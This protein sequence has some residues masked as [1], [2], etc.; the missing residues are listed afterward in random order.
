MNA[1]IH[2]L[3]QWHLYAIVKNVKPTVLNCMT[4]QLWFAPCVQ[5]ITI[6]Y[7]YYSGEILCIFFPNNTRATTAITLF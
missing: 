7:N 3:C 4:P 6:Y 5:N 2:S 1:E